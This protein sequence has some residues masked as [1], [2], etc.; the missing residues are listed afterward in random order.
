MQFLKLLQL[1]LVVF[2]ILLNNLFLVSLFG[3][4]AFLDNFLQ[5]SS[6]RDPIIIRFFMTI[7]YEAVLNAVLSLGLASDIKEIVDV[8]ELIMCLFDMLFEPLQLKVYLESFLTTD[9]AVRVLIFPRG[10]TFFTQLSE[11][12]DDST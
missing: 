10:V 7:P 5:A 6:V 8:I 1:F 4:F 9:V 11:L 2:L 12:I 3:L